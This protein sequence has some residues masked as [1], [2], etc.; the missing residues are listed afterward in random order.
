MWNE[1]VD[2]NMFWY[3]QL[4]PPLHIIIYGKYCMFLLKISI[5]YQIHRIINVEDFFLL[6]KEWGTLWIVHT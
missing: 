1:C 2:G 6:A 3:F 4:H 5:K